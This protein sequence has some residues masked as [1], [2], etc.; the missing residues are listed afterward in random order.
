MNKSQRKNEIYCPEINFH[1]KKGKRIFLFVLWVILMW[2]DEWKTLHHPLFLINQTE[3]R[4]SKREKRK[5]FFLSFFIVPS[6]QK[7]KN[8]KNKKNGNSRKFITHHIFSLKC[9]KN[10]I[11]R[12]IFAVQ[13]KE[14]WEKIVNTMSGFL[15]FWF[16]GKWNGD[17]SVKL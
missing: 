14:K 17:F 7:P 1:A 12:G 4:L 2:M 10:K 3:K 15:L 13:I 9:H 8:K 5:I 11:Y 6:L 16:V